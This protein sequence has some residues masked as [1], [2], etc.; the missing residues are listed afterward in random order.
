MVLL[1]GHN[2]VQ[3]RNN[4]IKRIFFIL[5]LASGLMA[6]DNIPLKK[7][8]INKKEH[9]SMRL[10][11]SWEVVE[12]RHGTVCMAFSPLDSPDDTFRE[13]VNIVIDS[14][15]NGIDPKPY[16][17][18]TVGYLTKQLTD[19]FL[20]KKGIE[21]IGKYQ[22]PWSI[23]QH[24]LQGND[25]TVIQYYFFMNQKVYIL[26]CTAQPE[27]FDD[28]METFR[29]IAKTLSHNLSPQKENTPKPIPKGL[30]QFMTNNT[31]RKNISLS[32]VQRTFP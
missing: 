1:I 13:N 10:P 23:F 25:L 30:D 15:D 16:L 3:E 28:T 27:V 4:M 5:V 21:T 6:E 14:N 31:I 8:Y 19:F 12:N 2:N 22:V 26:T 32:T 24:R 17:T 29:A 9:F 18:M 20:I 11:K 7:V